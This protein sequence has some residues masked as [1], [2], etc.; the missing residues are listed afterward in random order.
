MSPKGKAVGRFERET[1]K[2]ASGLRPLA[3]PRGAYKKIG[4]DP[5]VSPDYLS[6]VDEVVA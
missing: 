1:S 5:R 4:A 2:G 3:F 6:G